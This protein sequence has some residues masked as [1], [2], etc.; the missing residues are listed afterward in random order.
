[1]ES[2][3]IAITIYV[4]LGIY[5][6]WAVWWAIRK[7][8]PRKLSYT[9]VKEDLSNILGKD[10]RFSEN[11]EF[12]PH[13]L[14]KDYFY[15]GGGSWSPDRCPYHPKSDDFILWKQMS[16]SQR[17]EA[18]KRFDRMWKDKFGTKYFKEL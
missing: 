17:N 11:A 4:V 13:C 16:F 6:I 5:L 3:T 14:T 1:M 8:K 9:K 12:C 18:A 7:T 10:T 2:K 15:T